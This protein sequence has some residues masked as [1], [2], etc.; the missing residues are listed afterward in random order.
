VH[1]LW[2]GLIE[3]HRLSMDSVGPAYNE[4]GSNNNPTL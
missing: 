2:P 1:R 4:T 3:D